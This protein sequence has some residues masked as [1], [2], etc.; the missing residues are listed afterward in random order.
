MLNIDELLNK[1]GGLNSY[2]LKNI[3]IPNEYEW[4]ITKSEYL[5]CVINNI[6][7]RPMCVECDKQSSI[8]KSFHIGY[9]KYCSISCATTF[10]NRSRD[11]D[12]VNAKIK[13][14][15][16]NKTQEEK[17]E[18]IA[19]R[20]ETH[21]R[22]YGKY[23][24]N[25]EK[26]KETKL[27]NIDENGNNTFQRQVI[28]SKKTKFERYGDENYNNIEKYKETWY[29]SSDEY[30]LEVKLKRQETCLERYG[31][32]NY[33]NIEKYK[34]TCMEKY[35]VDNVRKADIIIN[36][37]QSKGRMTKEESGTF[38]PLDKK[39]DFEIYKRLVYKITYKQDLDSLDNFS[40]RAMIYT[41]DDAHNIDHKV[42][43][44]FGF[45]NNI[46]PYII[47]NILN[48]EMIPAI[49]N[50]TKKTKCSIDYKTLIEDFFL[51]NW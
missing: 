10:N 1:K 4:C 31:D 30:K 40:K 28:K 23:Y 20:K 45:D 51:P 5:Y 49:D 13:I 27:N 34:E 18:I 50:Y 36:K 37:I 46:P 47:G 16:M 39:S 32:E 14:A 35:G 17:D 7:S 8:F 41:I 6:S 11:T 29:S 25:P 38:I 21:K 19:N 12:L 48:L 2:K 44:K 24:C 26:G 9:S 3:I 43:I 42:S 22:K 15:W 33:N